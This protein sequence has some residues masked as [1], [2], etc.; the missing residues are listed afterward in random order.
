MVDGEARAAGAGGS[1]A[2]LGPFRDAL[3]GDGVVLFDGAMGTMLYAK[4][5]FIHRAFEEL[6]LSQPDLVR[7][8]HASY[9]EAGARVI[10]TNTF[11]ANR[12][13]L[14]PHG[15]V[16]DLGAIN[17]NGV[18]LARAAA[19]DR[20]WVAGAMG[21]IGVRIE[22][23]GPI[24]RAEAR[25]VFAQQA[26]A[27]AEAGVDLFILE[28]FAHLPE[29]EEAMRAVRGVTDLP[30]VA[31]VTVTAGGQTRE[32]VAADEAARRLEACGAD[33][34]GVNCSDALATLDAL[35]RM[36]RATRLPLT[37]QPN[38]GQPRSVAGRSIYLASPDYV[39]A[40]GRRAV[41][42][43]A[44]LLGGCCGTSPDHIAALRD[45]T[46]EGAA[47]AEAAVV[48]GAA[49]PSTAAPPVPLRREAKSALSR[50]LSAGTFVKGVEVH[51]P[52]GWTADRVLDVARRVAAHGDGWF[53]S[54]AEGAPA[55]ARIPPTALAPLCA[56]AGAETLVHY[57]C[58]GR[59]L[60]RMQAHLLGAYATE[61]RN[62][63][64]VTGDPLD[65][66]SSPDAPPDLEVDSVGA[67]HLVS[68]LNRGE[69]VAGNPIGQPTGFHVAVRLDPT[70]HD[71][72][73]EVARFEAKVQAG[74]EYAVTIP[75][76]DPAA[77]E[78]LLQRI[79]AGRVPVIATVWPLATARE[80]EFFEH[81]LAN[82]PVPAPLVDRMR[83]AEEAGRARDEGLAIARELTAA[84][85]P[86]VQGVLVV[87]PGDSPQDAM[88]I[89]EAIS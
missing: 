25:E 39:H 10:E 24:S 89:L 49:K 85:R 41:K 69:D 72:D 34:I 4:G 20:A 50:A 55:G 31:Q 52:L 36:R 57:S 22:P 17:R 33:A 6:N 37:G 16:G 45:L 12:F 84:L 88:G 35:E 43:G 29:L 48:P 68:R 13:R 30:M 64:V 70:A 58:R 38:A 14:A 61:V 18:E 7:E 44:R 65:P 28:T 53:V 86:L 81:Q 1:R 82:V 3:G 78:A 8:V 73:R 19:G 74:A 40:W 71:L 60:V 66:G 46:A 56:K 54:L 32:G 79:G 27:I 42:A 5:V 26:E 63:L 23:F 75:I 51:P 47:G 83:R 67:V 80:A 87:A 9:V 2:G 62:L 15:L 21:P 77:L 11:A 59:R 76:F